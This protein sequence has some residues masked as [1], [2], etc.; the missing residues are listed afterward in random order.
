M[1]T[2]VRHN[3][4][5]ERYEIS[6]DGEFAGFTEAHPLP[7]GTVLFPH[8]LLEPA[9]EGQGLASKLVAGALDD[10]RA[11]GLRAKVTCPYILGWLPK[12]P[13]YEDLVA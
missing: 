1:S 2:E 9:F 5:A 6:V 4:D 7:D 3:P 10:V 8:T 12:H 11:R 13:E